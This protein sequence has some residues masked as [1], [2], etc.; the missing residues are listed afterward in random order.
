MTE[1]IRTIR[2]LWQG[3]TIAAKSGNGRDINIRI[4]PPP[5]QT[6]LP[7]WIT[8]ASSPETFRMAGE[9]GANL[10]THTNDQSIPE[11][12]EKIAVYR[13]ARADK[14]FDPASG[15]V[16]VLLH[17][18]IGQDLEETLQKVKA[19]YC[20]YLKSNTALLKGFASSRGN[21]LNIDELPEKD[22]DEFLEFVFERFATER[23]L[24][25]R[26]NPA[27]PWWKPLPAPA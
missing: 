12:A 22:L 20:N 13:A 17:T 10:L 26:R 16:T 21:T 25:V 7:I 2:D 15:E 27:C 14:G 18:F 6:E 23:D 9:M 5:V 1:G 4:Y 3:R 24:S 19:P 8:A 11:L